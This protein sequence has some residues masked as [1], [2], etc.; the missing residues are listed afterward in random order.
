MIPASANAIISG[1]PVVISY[2]RPHCMTCYGRPGGIQIT[3]QG[4]D[5]RS[6]PKPSNLF[7]PTLILKGCDCLNRRTIQVSQTRRWVSPVD[8][9]DG[10]TTATKL[11]RGD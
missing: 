5:L 6:V 11:D 4:I 1:S 2:K 7:S 10:D 8:Y 9:T 3:L